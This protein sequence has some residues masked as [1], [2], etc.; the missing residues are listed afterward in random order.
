MS[1]NY[2]HA[3]ATMIGTVIG[4]GMFSIPFVAYKSGILVFLVMIIVLGFIQYYMHL[5]YAE[6]VLSTKKKHRVPGYVAQYLG[7]RY[8][9]PALVIVLISANLAILSF[10][11]IGG[12]FLSEIFSPAFGGSAFVYSFIMYIFSIALTY[13]GI[14]F[15]AKL[16][17]AMTI[18]LFVVIGI[19]FFAGLPH[20]DITNYTVISWKNIL[21]PYGAVFMAIG[22]MTAIPTV[23]SLLS[24]KKS[25]I[26]SA[27][28]WGTVIPMLI[29]ILFVLTIVGVSGASASADALAGLQGRLGSGVLII[30]LI[31]G[32]ISV[33]TSLVMFVE[34][35]KEIYWWDL[36]ISKKHAWEL[37][38][39]VPFVL[40]LFGINNL[41]SVV[42]LSGAVIGGVVSIIYILLILRVKA[43]PQ[44]KSVIEIK[45]NHGISFALFV[46]FVLGFVSVFEYVDLRTI[47][48]SSFVFFFYLYS[49]I[50]SDKNNTSIYQELLETGKQTSL[51]FVIIFFIVLS[52]GVFSVII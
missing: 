24:H 39:G 30:S 22:G 26:R 23:C 20:V 21:L 45:I 41:T 38:V 9:K 13:K 48:L 1:K 36:G 27:I 28:F 2:F 3:I 52:L 50:R 49:L 16:E 10:I 35:T 11:I 40:F 25:N 17:F 34:A 33:I 4:V 14:K 51:V 43:K 32:L 8:K 31:F 6:I 44:Q 37:S 42:S 46:L 19:I 47:A 7:P 5:M 15:I 18:L 29:T 12:I